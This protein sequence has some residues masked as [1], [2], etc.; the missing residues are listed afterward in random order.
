MDKLWVVVKREYVERVR[1]RWFV[2]AT[3][4]GPILFG[5]LWILP[6]LLASR[7]RTSADIANIVI[8]DA[9]GTDLGERVSSRLNGGLQVEAP[10]TRIVVVAPAALAQAESTATREVR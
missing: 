5:A 4:F 9:S 10:R 8:L 1:T 7:S 2:I 6:A 3:L